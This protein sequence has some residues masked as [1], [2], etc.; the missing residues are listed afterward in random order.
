M[1]RASGRSPL[2]A[3]V[4]VI[5]VLA[6]CGAATEPGDLAGADA[7]PDGGA[8]R[9]GGSSSTLP[10]VVQLGQ[11][12]PASSSSPANFSGVFGAAATNG[13]CLIAG[14]AACSFFDCR[15]GP[16]VHADSAGRVTV[17]GSGG[18]FVGPVVMTPS[19]DGFYESGSSSYFSVG[20]TLTV[21]ASGGQV[22]A[23]GPHSVVFPPPPSLAV[24]AGAMIPTSADLP[25]SWTGGQVGATFQL[26]GA[27][28]GTGYFACSWDAAGG[29][30]TVPLSILSRLPRGAG[31]V[32]AGQYATTAF[33]AGDYGVNLEALAYGTER[34]TFE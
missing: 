26:M 19:P 18:A 29:G 23:F 27:T 20:Q 7:A 33:A 28:S 8:E 2:R 24:A 30:G 6:G 13:A 11:A 12:F 16:A 34:V 22:P 17:T 32:F 9:D 21:E 1:M 5:T 3:S 15:V 4:V 10:A 25:V 14:D 31:S